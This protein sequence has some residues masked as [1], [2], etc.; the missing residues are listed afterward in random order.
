M[1]FYYSINLDIFQSLWFL[2]I[3][4]LNI[5]IYYK[6]ESKLLQNIDLLQYCYKILHKLKHKKKKTI[7]L[8]KME[9]QTKS[10]AATI[11]LKQ[12]HAILEGFLRLQQCLRLRIQWFV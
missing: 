4:I 1:P 7:H 5:L 8:E 9:I 3:C 11:S 12:N 6:F 2:A 10:Y